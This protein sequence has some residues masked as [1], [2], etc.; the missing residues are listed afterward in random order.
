[1]VKR[2]EMVHLLSTSLPFLNLIQ[3]SQNM[4]KKDE[5]EV[6]IITIKQETM[7]SYCI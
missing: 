6:D 5:F 7:G 1:M 2:L 4:Y 3:S